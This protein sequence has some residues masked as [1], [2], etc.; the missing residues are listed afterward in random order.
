MKK[1]RI[2]KAQKG[3][4]NFKFDKEVALVFDDMVSRSIPFYHEIHQ[5]L[6]DL[7]KYLIKKDAVIYDL[8]CSTGETILILDQYLRQNKI[9]AHFIGVDNSLPMLEVAHKKLVSNKVR[10]FELIHGDLR[11][12]SF[13]RCDFVIMNY[14]L[15]FIPIRDRL[16]LLKNLYHALR[17]NGGMVLSEKIAS[18][19]ANTHALINELYYDFKRRN[20]YSELEI[21]NKREALEKV[22]IPV[23][24]DK[25]LKLL[26]TAGFKKSD[27]IF[28]WYNFSSYLGLK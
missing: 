9:N 1:D 26:S 6:L 5:I 24:A 13:K 20:G 8:G 15:Q 4:S 2:F 19:S 27:M 3:P 25:Q 17:K 18:K 10:S 21:A 28:R 12:F 16:N 11:N 22:L 7:A 23:T 14:T